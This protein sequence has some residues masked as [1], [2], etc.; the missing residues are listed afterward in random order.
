MRK[1][2][3]IIILSN[4]IEKKLEKL[5]FIKTSSI[6]RDKISVTVIDYSIK[7]GI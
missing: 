2:H 7:G 1:T 5:T 4:L 3:M 6:F